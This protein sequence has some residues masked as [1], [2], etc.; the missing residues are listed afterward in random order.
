MG[1]FDTLNCEYP[2]PEEYRD[3]QAFGFQFKSLN[4]HNDFYRLATDGSLHVMVMYTMSEEERR[5]TRYIFNHYPERPATEVNSPIVFY[6]WRVNGDPSSGLVHFR[7][8][9]ENGILTREGIRLSTEEE[10][11]AAEIAFEEGQKGQSHAE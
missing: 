2:L 1:L 3:M 4:A 6:T 11:D 8:D 5:G 10:C 7:A 9:F